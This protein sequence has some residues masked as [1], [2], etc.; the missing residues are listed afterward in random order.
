M[1]LIQ[2]LLRLQTDLTMAGGER[3][4]SQLCSNRFLRY[5]RTGDDQP[6]LLLPGYMGR[7]ESMRQMQRFLRRCN[8]D[9]HGWGLGTNKGFKGSSAYDHMEKMSDNIVQKVKMLYK[10]QGRKVALVGHSLGGLYAR[11]TAARYPNL[12]DR[13]IT[14]G[15]PAIHPYITDSQNA[16]A[17][18]MVLKNVSTKVS[19][20]RRLSVTGRSGFLHWDAKFPEI[21]CVAIWSPVDGI[22][23]TE[24]ARIPDYI[25][26][27]SQPPAIRENIRIVCSHTGMPFNPMVFLAV[28]D[29]LSQATDDYELFQLEKY[30]SRR[31]IDLIERAFGNRLFHDVVYSDWNQ[32]PAESLAK[33]ETAAKPQPQILNRL[34]QD[35]RDFYRLYEIVEN[36]IEGGTFDPESDYLLL[37][38]VVRFMTDYLDRFHHPLEETI[39]GQL[40]DKHPDAKETLEELEQQHNEIAHAGKLLLRQVERA[41]DPRAPRDSSKLIERWKMFCEKLRNHVEMEEATL[42]PMAET[43]FSFTVWRNMDRLLLCDANGK[44]SPLSEEG[45]GTEFRQLFE[46]LAYVDRRSQKNPMVGD[47]SIFGTYLD[48]IIFISQ[49]LDEFL[50]RIK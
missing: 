9:A 48:S 33:G 20:R 8:F 45:V 7:D 24:A 38:D 31:S 26:Q 46:Y 4:I 16:L 37:A 30:F 39:F 35:H 27:L 44:D 36:S 32:G 10:K 13:V 11:E 1:A 3:V 18:D 41:G 5:A 22:V 12:I 29:R 43:A 15:S 6:V 49:A 47:N 14:I 23:Y 19:E 40:L 42:L 34:R 25:V 50:D 28:A 21:P 17:T 2:D